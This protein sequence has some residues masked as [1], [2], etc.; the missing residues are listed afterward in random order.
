MTAQRWANVGG[1]QQRIKK[2]YTNDGG[3]LRRIRER[4]A[5]DGGVPRLI[6]ADVDITL[7]GGTYYS[8]TS[9]A[10]A[11]FQLSASGAI[12]TTFGA[13]S[14]PVQ[15]A[16]LNPKV[17]MTDYQCFASLVSQ[18]GAGTFSGSFGA[19]IG[20][21]G[22]DRAW[23]ANRPNSAGSGQ[24]VLIFDLSIRRASDLV[25]LVSNARITVISQG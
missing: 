15:N 18:I 24:D 22:S 2:R 19:W 13:G 4:W 1:V 23:I 21:G 12:F 14:T 8:N 3:T 5:N 11:V 25:V 10:N 20:L 9:F 6:F 7:V 17:G 16:W